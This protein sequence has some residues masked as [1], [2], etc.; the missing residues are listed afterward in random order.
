MPKMV[1][2]ALLGGG[3]FVKISVLVYLFFRGAH[4]L[5]PSNTSNPSIQS[6][7]F[8][9]G[10]FTMSDQQLVDAF[11]ALPR[12]EKSPAGAG[13]NN[14]HFDVRYISLT[15]PSHILTLVQP[16]SGFFHTE[17][18]PVGGDALEYFPETPIEAAHEVAKAV[19]R[20]FV[21]TLGLKT[22]LG[23]KAPAAFGPW[24]LSTQDKDFAAAVSAEFKRI[25]VTA[26]ELL[27][28]RIAADMTNKAAQR[29]FDGFFRQLKTTTGFGEVESLLLTTPD[30]IKF[31]PE[32]R[33]K[34]HALVPHA[35]VEV[36]DMDVL[37]YAQEMSAV[38]PP[39]SQNF[40]DI[41]HLSDNLPKMIVGIRNRVLTQPEAVIRRKADEGDAE[42]AFDYGLR[43][44]VGLGCATNR[45]LS[46]HYL[47]KAILSPTGSD[48][49]KAAAH[50]VLIS[51][52]VKQ[53]ED[54]LRS[55]YLFAGAYHANEAAILCRKIAP[56]KDVQSSPAVLHFMF[57]VFERFSAQV[58]QLH[59][60][61]KD[62][63]QALEERKAQLA[64]E[65]AEMDRKRTEKPNR[66]QCANKGCGVG[67]N[68]GKMLSQCAGKCDSDRKPSYCSKACQKEDWPHHKPFCKPG[69]Q[70]SL[71]GAGVASS[72]RYSIENFSVPSGSQTRYSRPGA[73][74]M[75]WPGG[76]DK[77]PVTVSSSTMT[78]DFMKEVKTEIEQ[79]MASRKY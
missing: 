68:T 49:C 56:S 79:L 66:Y 26:R 36:D 52:N 21:D 64:E 72:S 44:Y 75:A 40:M 23:D 63:V 30:S 67:A 13:P 74:Q 47:V 34:A 10:L 58:P 11:N 27:T 76:R 59:L 50:G 39:R 45:A 33:K 25:G 20:A 18:L 70:S 46:R 15:P 35:G 42:A 9:K 12:K 24:A 28:V 55:R 71:A 48:E 57:N 8:K 22:H 53:G 5:L 61:C 32:R 29:A 62:G 16:K 41:S 38:V 73:Y 51:W 3:I 1:F 37:Q 43:L 65:D 31:Y 7:I 54:S 2:I 77:D 19:L 78:P 17:R 6:L 4:L 69:A 14:W 60:S